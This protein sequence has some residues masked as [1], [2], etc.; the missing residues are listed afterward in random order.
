MKQNLRPVRSFEPVGDEL[1][2]ILAAL[3]VALACVGLYGIASYNTGSC[4]RELGILIAF[5]ARREDV[6]WLR[7]RQGAVIAVAGVDVG[8]PYAYAFTKV[9]S[10]TI[11]GA[12]GNSPISS[13][14]SVLLIRPMTM[15]AI[16]IPAYPAACM[17]PT[18]VLRGE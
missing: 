10:R 7:L 15:L 1:L 17:D 8:L 3:A 9:A 16:F 12:G 4:S 5:S 13:L 14:V 11:V 18:V 2:G 6:L